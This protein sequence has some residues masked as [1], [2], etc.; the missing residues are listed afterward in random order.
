MPALLG[1]SALFLIKAVRIYTVSEF[2]SDQMQGITKYL[3]LIILLLLVFSRT[4]A[5]NPVSWKLTT[6]AA[7]K[8]LKSGDNLKATLKA[9][10]GGDW[11][12]YALDQPEGEGPRATKITLAEDKPF[13]LSATIAAR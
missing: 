7:G 9:T 4:P 2:R 5:Q 13:K 8:T 11:H 6:D 10:I 3:P 12:M 1:K